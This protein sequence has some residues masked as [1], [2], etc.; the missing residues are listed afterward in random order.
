MIKERIQEL[1][2]KIFND[3]VANRRHLHANPELSF[4]EVAT[5]AYVAAKLDELNI[6][7]VRMADNGL[8]G[9]LKGS[10]PSDQV[11]A[12][13]ADMDALPITEAN[14]VPYKSQ[15]VGVMHACGHDVHTSSLLGTATILSSMKDEFAGTVKLI[16][17]PAEEKLPGGA[18]LMI[19][20]GVLENP[21]PHAVLGQHVMPLI[22]AGKVGFRAG[23][24]MASTDE[25][26]VTVRGKG[27]HGAQPQQNIDPVIITAHMLTALQQVVSRFADPK[28]PS[29][30]SF[31]KV[32]A[33]G[34]TNI[35]PNEVY[36]EG[37][38]RTMDE[39]WRG[40]AHI[41]M[42][43]MAEGIAESMGGSCEFE[44]RRGYPF[45][46]NEE[47]LTASVR[48]HAEDYLGKEN[49]LDLDIWM[50]AEDFAYFSQAADSCFYRLGTRNESRGITSA[51]H[52]PTFDVEESALSVSTGLMA[53]MTLKQ[54][55]N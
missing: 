2:Q 48:A 3:V 6:P 15:N 18:N 24:Y 5:S 43:K 44:I 17:Q 20:Q 42:K 28:S 33:N 51:V 53:Y 8:V 27:G 13:R 32:I 16:F 37:T 47:K 45:L 4:N 35:I 1:S 19:Q 29:V 21:K 31:G 14:D 12:L 7:Y 26:Y 46:I 11:I 52:T 25:I 22:D 34:A 50:A 10:K 38:F 36:L 30:L 40:E 39:Q 49:V 9:L 54:L 41:R 23:K 55:G